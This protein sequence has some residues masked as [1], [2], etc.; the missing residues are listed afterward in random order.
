MA[1]TTK[2]YATIHQDPDSWVENSIIR[3]NKG[4]VLQDE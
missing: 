4:K 2:G 3:F 1:N